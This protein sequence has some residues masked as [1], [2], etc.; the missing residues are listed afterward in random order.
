MALVCILGISS[1]HHSLSTGPLIE[2]NFNRSDLTLK[3]TP[4]PVT[5]NLSARTDS[6]ENIVG[7]TH[8]AGA[9]V[10]RSHEIAAA[11]RKYRP[12]RRASRISR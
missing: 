10:P 7:E 5:I 8:V 11:V 12:T 1:T 9:R 4:T 2:T 3:I 6:P